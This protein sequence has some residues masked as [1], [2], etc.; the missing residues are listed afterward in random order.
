MLRRANRWLTSGWTLL[1]VSLALL[2]ATHWPSEFHTETRIAGIYLDKW[3][4]LAMYTPLTL[5]LIGYLSRRG[6][7]SFWRRYRYMLSLA[8]L[9]LGGAIDELTQPWFHRS[10]ELSDWIGDSVGVVLAVVV[11][12]ACRIVAPGSGDKCD[13]SKA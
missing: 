5:V 1:L 4:H 9:I 10:C 8:T 6:S 7:D 3:V 11:A 2:T 12:L 13:A